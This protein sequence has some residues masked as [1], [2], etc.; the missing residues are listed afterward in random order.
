MSKKASKKTLDDFIFLCMLNGKNWT[1]WQ[2]RDVIFTNTGKSYG[3]PT[4]SASIRNLRKTDRRAKYN[5]PMSG[6]VVVKRKL[7][8]GAGYEY[9]L[10]IDKSQLENIR[11]NLSGK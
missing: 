8:D 5:L 2:L 6:E 10:N 1:F 3:E 7:D 9:K 11:R 4:I